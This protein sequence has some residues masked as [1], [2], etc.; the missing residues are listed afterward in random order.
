MNGERG[1]CTPYSVVDILEN[2]RGLM[3][4]RSYFVTQSPRLGS[5]NVC[6]YNMN[7]CKSKEKARMFVN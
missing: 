1:L 6:G 3:R 2:D 5:L 4:G 7:A